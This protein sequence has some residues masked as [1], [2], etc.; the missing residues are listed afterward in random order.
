MP[1][2]KKKKVDDCPDTLKPYRFHGVDVNWDEKNCTTECPFC[3]ADKF[4]IKVETGQ[5]R[6]FVCNVSETGRGLNKSSFLRKMHERYVALNANHGSGEFYENLA[7]DRGVTVDTLRDAGIMWTGRDW[8]VPAYNGD[9]KMTQ[10]YRYI[11]VEKKRVCLPTPTCGAGM[12]GRDQFDPKS[13][14]QV[15]IV[16]G[17]WDMLS[18]RETI[19]RHNQKFQVVGIPGVNVFNN[20]WLKMFGGKDVILMFD[21]DSPKEHADGR[22]TD[23]GGVVGLRY[24]GSKLKQSVSPPKSIKFLD[25]GGTGLGYSGDF[26][27]GADVRD[28]LTGSVTI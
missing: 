14:H 5:A 3:G 11:K 17:V 22:K 18:L 8:A 23:K 4:V 27:D 1:K 21:N 25:W 10:L 16:E 26:K 13:K 7:Q 9:G 2:L 20:Y 19:R 12:F 24:V 6:C 15:I 28:V